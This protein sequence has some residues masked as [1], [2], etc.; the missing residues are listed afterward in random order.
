[1]SVSTDDEPVARDATAPAASGKPAPVKIASAWKRGW[2]GAAM[3]VVG[4]LAVFAVQDR[5]FMLWFHNQPK[6]NFMDN[7]LSYLALGYF[8]YVPP[9]DLVMLLAAF[10]FVVPIAFSAKR[11][12]GPP[13]FKVLRWTIIAALVP[14][15]L[16]ALFLGVGGT[17]LL[18]PL[19]AAPIMV[20]MAA[21]VW[22]QTRWANR[23]LARAYGTPEAPR[24]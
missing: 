22:F 1:M 13:P 12:P 4:T 15:V 21:G 2:I 19:T 18:F 10:A 7:G 24:R 6:P 23:D 16:F 14:A 3:A 8:I 9:T 17:H 20:A 5:L 11:R